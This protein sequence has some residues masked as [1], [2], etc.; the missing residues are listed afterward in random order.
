MLDG[1]VG[2]EVTANSDPEVKI[3]RFL[4]GNTSMISLS[5]LEEMVAKM[6]SSSSPSSISKSKNDP[7]LL[8]N[9]D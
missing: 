7:D 9:K 1:V 2:L 5:F 8:K 6:A 4:P 3:W